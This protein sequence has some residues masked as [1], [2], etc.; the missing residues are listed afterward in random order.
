MVANMKIMSQ[1]D[2]ENGYFDG[3]QDALQII[4]KAAA[5]RKRRPRPEGGRG[6]LPGAGMPGR[7]QFRHEDAPP[8]DQ[9]SSAQALGSRP[10]PPKE[11]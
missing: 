9:R 11:R 2:Y 3:L 7:A 1:K 5:A 6:G 8:P 10:D 4:R